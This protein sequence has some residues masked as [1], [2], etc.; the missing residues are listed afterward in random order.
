MEIKDVFNECIR[1]NFS[2]VK[3]LNISLDEIVEALELYH[4]EKGSDIK[5]FSKDKG[6]LFEFIFKT[7][8]FIKCNYITNLINSKITLYEDLKPCYSFCYTSGWKG[9]NDEWGADVILEDKIGKTIWAYTS[10]SRQ[11]ITLSK[12]EWQRML[13][14]DKNLEFKDKE[15]AIGF[16]VNDSNDF[17][18]N[19]SSQ[20][21]DYKHS[22]L[23]YQDLVKIWDECL[24]I[25][26]DYNW[27][28]DKLA[29][30]VREKRI[31]YILMPHQE[32]GENRAFNAFKAGEKE[33]LFFWK[34]RS[35]KTLAALDLLFRKMDLK[36][37]L[38][39][40]NCPAVNSEWVDTIN[41]FMGFS[42]VSVH[43]V[44]GDKL[45]EVILHPTKNN[46]VIIST[47]D[48]V[49]GKVEDGKEWAKEKF[50][51]LEGVE[52]DA[53]L[54]DEVHRGQETKKAIS[55]KNRINYKYCLALSATPWK[56]IA[57]GRFGR[58]NTHEWGIVDEG[59]SK[60][61]NKDV[62]G[63]YPAMNFYL[64]TIDDAIRKS[65]EDDGYSKEE[66]PTMKKIFRIK[67]GKLVHENVIR[68]MFKSWFIKISEHEIN[69]KHILAFV[70]N[71]R[72]LEPLCILMQEIFKDFEV[73][74]TH[75]GINPTSK[76]LMSFR[77]KLHAKAS[78]QG[79][80][81]IILAV[82]QL[83]TGITLKKCD[84]ILHLDDGLST[85]EYIQKS[86]RAQNPAK[87]KDSCCIFDF[88]PNRALRC[89]LSTAIGSQVEK[90]INERVYNFL[91]NAAVQ[92]MSDGK[93]IT[94]DADYLIKK[95]V[96]AQIKINRNLFNQGII[97]SNVLDN[98]NETDLYKQLDNL[99]YNDAFVNTRDNKP[100]FLD[101]NAIGPGLNQELVEVIDHEIPDKQ[102]I[103]PIINDVDIS[104]ID[105]NQED[106]EKKEKKF[107][108]TIRQK[109]ERLTVNFSW[110][111]AITHFKFDNIKDIVKFLDENEEE[112]KEFEFLISRIDDK[113][114]YPISWDY[115]KRLL[116]AKDNQGRDL[117]NLEELDQRLLVLVMDCKD[118]PGKANELMITEEQYKKIFGEVFTPA[119]LVNE[120]LD[121]LPVEVW[122]DKDLTWCDPACGSGNFLYQVKIRLMES[123][124]EEIEDEKEREK[125]IVE[126]ML[127]GVELQRKNTY[128]CMFKLDPENEFNVNIACEDSLK[129]DFWGMKFDVIVGNPP[130]QAHQEAK[131][132]RGGGDQLWDKFV[133]L[134]LDKIMVGNGY[135]CFVHP[136]IWR[137]PLS[138]MWEKMSKIQFLYLE[139]HDAKDGKEMFKAGTRYDFYVIKNEKYFYPTIVK[140]EKG[141]EHNI[142]FRDW[143]WL[144]NCEFETIKKILDSEEEVVDILFSTSFYETRKNWMSETKDETHPYPCVHTTAK[145]KGIVFWWSSLNNKGFFGEPKVVFGDGGSI[146][147]IID[148]NGEYAMTQHAM[149]IKDD[150]QKLS[151]IQ[152]AINS[153]L[154]NDIIQA[155]MWSNFQ[156]DWRMF[157]FFK[158]DFWK[159]FISE[160]TE[161][162][163][164]N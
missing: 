123:L 108:L 8:V 24:T 122:S 62:Y 21:G 157:K 80:G 104:E 38:L 163:Q 90:P 37:I 87:D 60:K 51:N 67:K 30:D 66:Y 78:K 61:I 114:I 140:D 84:C 39:L 129:F 3:F 109:L 32:E 91:S 141:L 11:N 150:P 44:S 47:Q 17:M 161:N 111:P 132:K 48:S 115:I 29:E 82:G 116:N 42:N 35:G 144:P 75:S 105:F 34:C 64:W 73:A 72:V 101:P 69:P 148:I 98:L 135:L 147:A 43:N 158:K 65:L 164:S 4:Q 149:A 103:Q 57:L 79:K 131:G 93:W 27:D 110:L 125:W 134:C 94:L 70:P 14:L 146:N 6:R 120:M 153:K 145:S 151:S 97:N 59:V 49:S 156:I 18:K 138:E 159:E 74:Y 160:E 154:F 20:L 96:E 95:G 7:G 121:K 45:N 22:V 92:L 162:E 76:E 28:L 19:R 12:T 117:I 124:K 155:C 77:Q 86:L 58:H 83:T 2:N 41:K 26:N 128:L 71:T 130:Y 133:D 68:R 89:I 53:L 142:D 137:K 52:W 40:T 31:P 23:D 139:I 106:K 54:L 112:R 10:K 152:K 63:K 16:I 5:E 100:G 88:N 127:Y 56:N 119:E 81:T 126:K 25:F 9:S 36:N 33:F 136:A 13:N 143:N 85:A 107:T 15:I 1:G 55:L 102:Q 113:T 118:N 99:P 46:L 50:S